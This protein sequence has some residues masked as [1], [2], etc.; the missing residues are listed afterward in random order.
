MKNLYILIIL[1]LFTA[2]TANSQISWNPANGPYGGIVNKIENNDDGKMFAGATD[3]LY[4]SDDGAESWS[5]VDIGSMEVIDIECDESGNV[6]AACMGGMC[7]S[8]D[9][10]NNWSINCGDLGPGNYKACRLNSQGHIYT[11]THFS[12]DWN[13]IHLSTNNGNNW[14]RIETNIGL[15][16]VINVCKGN[17]YLFVGSF[18]EGI[19]RSKDN[20]KTVL[21]SG[22]DSMS[23]RT[24]YFDD[25]DNVYAGTQEEGVYVSND[26]G[27]S[28]TLLGLEGYSVYSFLID[29][30]DIYYAG[31]YYNGIFTSTNGGTS[32]QKT[33]EGLFDLCILSITENGDDIYSASMGGGIN[34]F[35]KSSNKWESCSEGISN[36]DISRVG[37]GENNEIY[38][39]S[40]FS[41]FYY[42]TNGG[43]SWENSSKQGVTRIN[44][45]ITTATGAVLIG[46]WSQGIFRTT[47]NGENWTGVFQ[48]DANNRV[49]AFA[50]DNS[51]AIYTTVINSG[52]LRSTNDGL[53][54][55]GIGLSDVTSI[56]DICIGDDGS[57]FA[58]TYSEGLFRSVDNGQTWEELNTQVNTGLELLYLGDREILSGGY[59]GIVERSTDNG[60]T[61]LQVYN[62]ISEITDL[63]ADD[64]GLVYITTRGSGILVSDNNGLNWTKTNTGLPGMNTYSLTQNESGALFAGTDDGIYSTEIIDP[65]LIAQTGLIS[66]S[67]NSN[68]IARDTLLKWGV[69]QGALRYEIE[70]AIDQ[71]FHNK[72]KHADSIEQTSFSLFGL[73]YN[74][75]YYWRVRAKNDEYTGE[76]SE[77]WQFKTLLPNPG[78]VFPPQASFGIAENVQFEWEI[79]QNITMSYL[80]VSSE[81]DFEPE[82][83]LFDGMTDQTNS[84]ETLLFNNTKY[85]WRIKTKSEDNESGWSQ[86]WHFTV[87][88][89]RPILNSPADN[90]GEIADNP[91]LSW[92]TVDDANRYLIQIALDEDFSEIALERYDNDNKQLVDLEPETNYYWHIRA[93][94]DKNHSSWS[95]TWS[96]TTM[97]GD[98]TAPVLKY[99]ADN[100]EGLGTDIEFEWNE[101][102]AAQAD[103]IIIQVSKDLAFDQEIFEYKFTYQLSYSISGLDNS[104]CYYWRIRAVI[105]DRKSPWSEIRSFSTGANELAAPSLILPENNTETDLKDIQFRWA[106]VTNSGSYHL[107]V[108]E[109]PGFNNII[110]NED[111]LTENQMI[112]DVFENGSKYYW[113][114]KAKDNDTEGPWSDIWNFTVNRTGSG[115]VSAI[116]INVLNL[117]PNPCSGHL[118]ISFGSDT[119]F[120]ESIEIYDLLSNR[121]LQIETDNPTKLQ[122]IDLSG[123]DLSPGSF[124]VRII[125]DKNIYVR[126]IIKK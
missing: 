29:E 2:I 53:T 95:E 41:G 94:N 93:F 88:L 13:K 112:A 114:V 3:G 84:H 91:V 81:L 1:F 78:L 35:D 77:T 25:E 110:I 96:F 73:E 83:L 98:L 27:D 10:G 74:T 103:S 22:L 109:N 120:M 67:N 99:P 46:T 92:E 62:T 38:V 4:K 21:K 116:D 32:W 37:T 59:N 12:H 64:E 101:Y 122:I 5:K 52:I 54:W 28:W 42:S 102:T 20:G 115:I 50:A 45:I 56:N 47:D 30:D 71:A 119:E 85:F 118:T 48:P 6:Y 80:Q 18:K 31:T 19:W 125:T 107:Q 69:T 24:I 16:Q 49:G 117:H 26:E 43:M 40:N 79:D 66:P 108:S 72:I 104:T 63:V 100:E 76:W 111:N 34:R 113:R 89:E 33:N 106:P 17:D 60:D 8:S 39:A 58:A 55:E 61:W 44:K 9:N 65:S 121:L 7:Y 126:K 87:E 75:T 97:P 82:N 124:M 68:T 90:S 123:I 51:G 14:R 15:I 11:L 36:V 23:V 86:I 105:G 57:I 70:V